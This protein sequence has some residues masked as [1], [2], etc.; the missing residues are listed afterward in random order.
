MARPE[1]RTPR[2]LGMGASIKRTNSEAITVGRSLPC[3]CSI[4]SIPVVT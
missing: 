3:M 2:S 4:L 1:L